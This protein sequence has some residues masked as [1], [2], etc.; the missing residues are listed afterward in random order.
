MLYGLRQ[1]V[2]LWVCLRGVHIV[3]HELSVHRSSNMARFLTCRRRVAHSRKSPKDIP[4]DVCT[5]ATLE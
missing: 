5:V 3:H 4:E 2:H 1:A